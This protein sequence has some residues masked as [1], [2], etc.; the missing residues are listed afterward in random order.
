MESNRRGEC[1]KLIHLVNYKRKQNFEILIPCRSNQRD[2]EQSMFLK[3]LPPLIERLNDRAAFEFLVSAHKRWL[4]DSDI[5]RQPKYVASLSSSIRFNR[6]KA[7][8][9]EL[10]ENFTD[11]LGYV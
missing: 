10:E 7:S 8:W 4:S 2:Q 6:R 5:Y 9:L 11:R 1:V 3:P